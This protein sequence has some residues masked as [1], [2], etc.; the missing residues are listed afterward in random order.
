MN[1]KKN[2]SH[3]SFLIFH[4]FIVL[5]LLVVSCSTTKKNPG[6]IDILRNQA[7]AWLESGT[8]E[9]AQGKF[10]NALSI[11]TETKRNAILA[12]NHSLIVRVCMARGNVLYSLG[13]TDDAFNEWTQAIAEAVLSKDAELLSISKIYM[14][15]GNLISEKLSAKSILDE[16]NRER[17]NLT[18]NRLYTA[19]SWQVTGLAQ[20]A[21]GSYSDAEASFRRSL[22][23]HEKNSYL[24]NAS[25]DWFVIASIRSM[26]GNTQGAI[27]ALESSIT[28]DRRIENSWGL[29]ASYRAM[30]DVYKKMGKQKEAAQAY[31][32]SRGIY[33]AMRNDSEV[34]EIDRRM[35]EL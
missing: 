12:D 23:I 9:A 24:E 29:A 33:A 4:L 22:E 21:L 14:A 5:S 10:D 1:N 30:G 20:R 2:I 6:D 3:F 8:K 7:E 32:R 34:A 27:Q 18:K 13:R 26:S 19:F 16:V 11:L 35:R 17:T 15:K 25:Y 31:G 28:Y